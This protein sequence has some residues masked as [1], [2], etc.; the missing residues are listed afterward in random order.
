M[1]DDRWQRIE[2]VFHQAAELSAP[3]RAPF[4]A[5]VC[6][7]DDRLQREVESLLEH[8]KTH[9][10]VLTAAIVEAVN[11]AKESGIGSAGTNEASEGDPPVIGHYHLL[12][13]IGKGGM[14]VVWLA[15]QQEPVRRFV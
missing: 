10:S 7:G 2:E 11:G 15:E 12:R 3:E 5:A 6:A 9:D 4:L 1:N 14:G 13:E 8:D